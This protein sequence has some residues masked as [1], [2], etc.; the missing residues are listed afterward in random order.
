MKSLV[1]PRVRNL[2]S[3]TLTGVLMGALWS[4][5][6]YQHMKAFF[7]TNEWSY[8]VICISETLGA[9]F[10][11]TRKCP[12]SVST[13][14][15]DWVIGVVGTFAS[16]LFLPAEW[17]A[18]PNAK[19]AIIAGTGLTVLGM[20]SLNRSFAIVAAKREIKTS[21]MYRFVRHPLYASYL[22]T[23]TGYVLANTTSENVVVYVF[24]IGC[25]FVRMFREERHLALDHKYREYM[26]QVRYRVIPFVF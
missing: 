20:I 17:G 13:A 26:Q 6:S 16:F 2:I 23:L 5:F 19:Y 14:P 1:Q 7:M 24:T 25:M 10:F 4:W 11:I 12:D 22:L 21:G 8:L 18:V 9:V 3:H 15:L